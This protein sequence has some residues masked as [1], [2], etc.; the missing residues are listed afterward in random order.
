MTA[1]TT[2]DAAEPAAT[3][4]VDHAA[5]A[6]HRGSRL[7]GLV[8]TALS[9]R[10]PGLF[11][12]RQH[13]DFG[14]VFVARSLLGSS[15][16]VADPAV[17]ESIFTGPHDALH[18]GAGN[19]IFLRAI[20]G[21]RGILVVDGEEHTT[22]RKALMPPFRGKAIA[23]YEPIIAAETRRRVAT[24]AVGQEITVHDEARAITLEVILRAVF[25]ATEGAEI[26]ELRTA[27]LEASDITL[28]RTLWTVRPQLLGKFWP[29]KSY[30][31]TIA[32]TNALL[33]RMIAARRTATDLAERTDTLS[34]LVRDSAEDD[35][36]IR[37]QLMSLL[38]A[39]HET[40]TTALSWAMELLARHPE[41]RAKARESGDDYLDAVINETLR[42]RPVISALS[43][44][45]SRPLTLGGYSLRPG[46]M[47]NPQVDTVH[48]DARIWGDPEVFRPERFLGTRHSTSTYFP[49]GGGKRR[50][51]GA[52]FAHTEMRVAL[53][54][55]LEEID[56]EPVSPEP[57]TQKISH[58]TLAPS[59]GALVRRTR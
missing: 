39:G 34:L 7:P 25:G 21:D 27:V 11:T 56:F 28:L 38:G 46:T 53:R 36:W 22:T 16:S 45:V 5:L 52:L 37:D 10:T 8:Q 4:P 54:T 2:H 47:L 13:A 42:I 14:D 1:V 43:R 55:I 31:R 49:Y 19:A 12:R 29:W 20:F 23:P 41:V 3:C 48:R 32:R 6:P 17:V 58:I 59:R 33:D 26:D 30:A 40:T 9:L 50:C 44:K 35:D 24:W 57:E 18:A 15:V 51:I